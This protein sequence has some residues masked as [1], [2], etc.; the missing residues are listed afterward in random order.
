SRALFERVETE[1]AG[2]PGV[3]S[4][5]AAMVPLLANSRWGSSLEIESL[6]SAEAQKSPH[7]WYNEISPGDFGKIGIPLIAGREFS[8]ADNPAGPKVA[9]VNEEF[10]RQFYPKR[11][12]IGMHFGFWR[13]K[14]DIEVIA[15]VKDSHYGSVREK[16]YPTYYIPWRQDK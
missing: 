13:G 6:P 15:V 1:L 3:S 8:D 14:T 7:A 16:P 12:P 2:I 11:N 9:I 4:A 10:V 5:S